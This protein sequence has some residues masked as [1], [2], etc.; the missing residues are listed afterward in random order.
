MRLFT[1]FDP[2]DGHAVGR[3]DAGNAIELAIHVRRRDRHQAVGLHFRLRHHGARQHDGI[4]RRLQG[5]VVAHADVRQ[6]Q[7]HRFGQALAHALD[8]LGQGFALCLIHH[9]HQFIAEHHHQRLHGRQL[10]PLHLGRLVLAQ[11]RLDGRHAGRIGPLHALGQA[12]GDEGQHAGKGHEHEP[13]HARDQGQRHHHAGRAEDHR[14]R[15][16]HLTRHLLFEVARIADTGHQDGGRGRQQQRRDLRHQAIT[17]GQQCVL[18]ESIAERQVVHQRADGHAADHVDDQDQDTGDGIAAHELRR[19]VHGAIEIGFSGHVLAAQLGF[20]LVDQAGVQVGVDGHLLARQG[21]EG[22]ARGHFRD[23]LGTLGD[24]GEVDD[25]QDH[26]DHDTDDEVTSDHHVTE[27]LDHLTGRVRAR[28]AVQQHHARRRHVQRQPEHG[29]G[30]DHR[31]EDG[32]IERPLGRH[33]DQDDDQ[34]QHDIESEQ[35]IEQHRRQRQ[36]DHCQDHQQEQRRGELV[37]AHFGNH[38]VQ[39]IHEGTTSLK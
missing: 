5:Q 24:D 11:G 19:A 16:Q 31:R 10:L 6:Q 37:A 35:D 8:A 21:I 32:E 39:E 4:L 28:M 26:E 12:P 22:K 2:G 38:A 36:D 29:G 14:W 3:F 9:A 33:A 18:T 30:Q 13:R 25:H 17:D 15:S 1:G 7:A 20:F 27:G 34:G 23:A